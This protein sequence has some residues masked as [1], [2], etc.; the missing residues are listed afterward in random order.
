LKTLKSA[1][2]AGCLLLTTQVFDF[3]RQQFCHEAI[4]TQGN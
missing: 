1:T 3:E 2:K 4:S